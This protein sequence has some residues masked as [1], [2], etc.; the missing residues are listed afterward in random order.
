[1]SRWLSRSSRASLDHASGVRSLIFGFSVFSLAFLLVIGIA[2]PNPAFA[3]TDVYNG[4]EANPTT[5][6][7]GNVAVGTTSPSQTDTATNQYD[8]DTIAFTSFF[9][10]SIF[11][12]AGYTITNNTCG[13]TLNALQPCQVDVACEPTKTG[14]LFGVLAFFYTSDE[15]IPPN[16]LWDGYPMATFVG[17][18]CTGVSSGP[19]PTPTATATAATPTAT[20][21]QTAT[22]TAT[23]TATSTGSG[24]ATNSNLDGDAQRQLRRHD[25]D[26]NRNG[27]R[28]DRRRLHR[29][30]PQPQPIRRRRPRLPPRRRR[31]RR[32][33]RLPIRQP[34]PRLP[35]QPPPIRR[36]RLQPTRRPRLPPP[37]QL[38][39][40]QRL[41]RQLPLRPVPLAL[42]PAAS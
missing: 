18:T 36:P 34:R 24:N 26:R 10:P 32:L 31:R 33:Q 28:R 20:A 13:S 4:L 11:A 1:M 6:S 40:R 29:D 16:D 22:A 35:P 39:R 12:T 38:E 5:L 27:D 15:I 14:F 2:A 25:L 17:L 3:D 9:T 37:P 23:A 21:T 42:K 30:A 19:T 7:F 41:R 8:D